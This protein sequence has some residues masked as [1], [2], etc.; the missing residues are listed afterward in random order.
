MSSYYVKGLDPEGNTIFEKSVDGKHGINSI[1]NSAT[2]KD[3]VKTIVIIKTW[4]R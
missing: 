3:T 4:V 2:N 1:V